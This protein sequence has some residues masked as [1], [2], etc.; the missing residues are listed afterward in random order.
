M[1]RLAVLALLAWLAALPAAA[2][3][4]QPGTRDEPSRLAVAVFGRICLLGLGD[5]GA[6]DS[7]LAPG[8]EFGFV[9]VPQDIAE[10]LLRGRRGTVRALRRP[11]L[12]TVMVV[13]GADGICSVWSQWAEADAVRRHMAAMVERGGLQGGGTLVPA[14]VKDN[15]GSRTF[16]WKL[17]PEGWYAHD[18]GR[19]TGDD[20]RRPVLVTAA[21]WPPGERPFEGLLSAAR[22]R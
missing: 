15:A 6:I 3:T 14:G 9:E 7:M 2:Q 16:E 13:A 11:G 21:L 1:R 10:T 19:R 12:G 17:M 22:G 4:A 18:L 8:N 20:G 5:V